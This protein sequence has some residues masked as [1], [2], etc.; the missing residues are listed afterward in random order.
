MS[1][2]STSLIL[3]PTTTQAQAHQEPR[4]HVIDSL[5]N[6]SKSLEVKK[7]RT[8]KKFECINN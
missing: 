2:T 3:N 4:R 1:K 7:S 6:F 8:G 5:L